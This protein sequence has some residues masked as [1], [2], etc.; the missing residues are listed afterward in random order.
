MEEVADSF[1]NVRERRSRGSEGVI[2]GLLRGSF[3]RAS[4]MDV[5]FSGDF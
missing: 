3:S 4:E 5:A 1:T 2:K